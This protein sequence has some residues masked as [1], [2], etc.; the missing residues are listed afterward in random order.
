MERCA[1]NKFQSSVCGEPEQRRTR[2]SHRNI[3]SP[4]QGLDLLL[5]W[6]EGADF[7]TPVH[8]GEATH[9]E[10]HLPW[11]LVRGHSLRFL[12]T[13]RFCLPAYAVYREGPRVPDTHDSDEQYKVFPAGPRFTWKFWELLV[14]SKLVS[15]ST[16][17]SA[18]IFFLSFINFSSFHFLSFCRPRYF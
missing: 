2:C 12:E 4:E 8:P 7:Q 15:A 14:N 16:S 5:P 11:A 1:L 3:H 17:V 9:S 6:R 10:G 18:N 13:A